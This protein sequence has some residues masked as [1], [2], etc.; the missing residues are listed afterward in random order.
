MSTGQQIARYASIAAVALFTTLAPA[1]A[2]AAGPNIDLRRSSATFSAIPA[3][4][5]G[6]LRSPLSRRRR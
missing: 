2:L 5:S 4:T 3:V 1:S 6:G